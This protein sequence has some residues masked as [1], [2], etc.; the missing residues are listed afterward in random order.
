MESGAH[1]FGRSF[2]WLKQFRVGVRLIAAAKDFVFDLR[3]DLLVI[4][5]G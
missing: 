1:T 5:T 4:H 2:P 3:V